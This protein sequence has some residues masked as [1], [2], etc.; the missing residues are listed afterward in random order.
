MVSFDE[1]F[2]FF[3]QV[4]Q[5]KECRGIVTDKQGNTLRRFHTAFGNGGGL[6][7]SGGSLITARADDMGDLSVFL[8]SA[9]KP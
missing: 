3:L 8:V 1:G 9:G 4:N 2:V 5:E 7:G 6:F